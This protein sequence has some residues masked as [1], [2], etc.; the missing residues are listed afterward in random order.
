MAEWTGRK[1]EL[2]I[3]NSGITY[4]GVVKKKKGG[5]M[6]IIF[7]NTVEGN[8][9]FLFWLRGRS[10]NFKLFYFVFILPQIFKENMFSLKIAKTTPFITVRNCKHRNYLWIFRFLTVLGHNKCKARFCQMKNMKNNDFYLKSPY[11]TLLL[12]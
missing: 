3:K 5:C 4:E 1:T 9:F 12:T 8:M 2:C 11:S 7:F 10:Y 6:S